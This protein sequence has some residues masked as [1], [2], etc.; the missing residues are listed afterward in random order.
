[1]LTGRTLEALA[2]NSPLREH[3]LKG[4]WRHLSVESKLML[5]DSIASEGPTIFVPKYLMELASRD[6]CAFVTYWA[7][8]Y[9]CKRSDSHAGK[10]EEPLLQASMLDFDHSS[11]TGFEALP[12]LARL[13]ALRH[14]EWIL[15]DRFADFV[16]R[17][18]GRQ[19]VPDEELAECVIEYF[20]SPN[21]SRYLSD[22][23]AD[24]MFNASL[25]IGAEKIW[26]SVGR[27]GKVAR[28]QIAAYAPVFVDGFVLSAD[29]FAKLPTVSQQIVM[30]RNEP[31]IRTLR[32]DVHERPQLYSPEVVKMVN[33]GDFPEISDVYDSSRPSN[34]F[35]QIGDALNELRALKTEVKQLAETLKSSKQVRS[36]WWG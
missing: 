2:N 34:S 4:V 13:N 18:G 7:R 11:L 6:D 21:Y 15:L 10:V 5:I 28:N 26:R 31:H 29:E 24:G 9:G 27:I 17:A 20:H 25:K 12:H 8:R 33:E 3:L 1:M 30:H 23:D 19:L 16:Q 14:H 36:R 22:N 32:N 35:N